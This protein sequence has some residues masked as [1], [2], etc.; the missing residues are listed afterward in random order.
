MF[1]DAPC[2]DNDTT[3]PAEEVEVSK[4]DNGFK[5][6]CSIP[7]SLFSNIIGSKGAVKKRIEMETQT[8]IYVPRQ[9]E[10]GD[11]GT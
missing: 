9:N 10:K 4:E 8:R 6:V 1:V 5:V 7:S 11:I 3:D 2:L